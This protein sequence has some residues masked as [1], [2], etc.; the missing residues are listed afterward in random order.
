[1]FNTVYELAADTDRVAP[2]IGHVVQITGAIDSSAASAVPR[3]T[4]DEIRMIASSCP[5]R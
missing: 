5:G 2:H 1:V 3:L 4:V